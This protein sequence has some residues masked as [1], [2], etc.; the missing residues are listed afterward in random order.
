MGWRRNIA[1]HA[2]ESVGF[3]LLL[4]AQGRGRRIIQAPAPEA[5]DNII[6]GVVVAAPDYEGS[7]DYTAAFGP[8][9]MFKFAGDRNFRLRSIRGDPRVQRNRRQYRT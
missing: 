7:D 6:G 9:A 5:F 8:L 2:K 1:A 4:G 3:L